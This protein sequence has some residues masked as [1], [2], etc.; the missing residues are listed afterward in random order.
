MPKGKGGKRLQ[1]KVRRFGKG[2]RT[3]QNVNYRIISAEEPMSPAA[4]SFRR[5]KVG[6]DFL[7]ADGRIRVVQ[8][9]SS[10]QGEGKTTV[11]LNLATVYAEEGKRVLLIDLDLR[12][13]KM[14]RAFRIEN[15]KGIADYLAG[16]EKEEEIVKNVARNIDLVNSGREVPHPAS[17]LGSK[18]LRDFVERMREKYDMILIDCPPTLLVTDACITSGMTDGTI[19]VVSQA[20]T[21][22]SAAKE[23]VG[24][25]RKNNI[26][27]LGCVMTE[28]SPDLN[29]RSYYNYHSQYY[30][31]TDQKNAAK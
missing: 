9:C 15:K 8:V 22:K 12:R 20:I 14:H 27:L 16:Y 28:V 13:P 21:E 3:E 11:L 18:M 31:Y 23:A 30:S 29:K 1:G 2:K 17:V 10:V 19:F 4:E 7:S 26:R 6:L 24:I 25:F 5:L